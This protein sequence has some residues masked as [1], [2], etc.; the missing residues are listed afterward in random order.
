VGNM[1]R[2]MSRS[3]QIIAITHLHQ[4]A[5]QGSAHYFVYKDNSS[6]KTVSR[7]KK[8]T[9]EERVMEIAQMIGGQ[10]PSKAIVDNA[11]EI[12]SKHLVELTNYKLDL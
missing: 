4:I 1:M 5:A 3:H 11:R 12:L 8:L 10:N 2:E 9:N 7:I 6:A